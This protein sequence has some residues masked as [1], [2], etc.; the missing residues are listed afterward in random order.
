MNEQTPQEEDAK[1]TKT[2]MELAATRSFDDFCIGVGQ[3]FPIPDHVI[4]AGMDGLISFATLEDIGW[5]INA[6]WRCDVNFELF[7]LETCDNRKGFRHINFEVI[8]ATAQGALAAGIL[9]ILRDRAKRAPCRA[10]E[11]HSLGME[12]AE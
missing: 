9:L 10:D 2:L 4:D 7:S 12:C 5:E 3:D 11:E 6:G 8:A 1:F